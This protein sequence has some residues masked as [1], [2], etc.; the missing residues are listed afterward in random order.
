MWQ[1]TY[2]EAVGGL[3]YPTIQ[4]TADGGYVIATTSSADVWV[5]KLDASGNV[6]WQKTYGGPS[7]DQGN[8]IRQTAD[9]GYIVAGT[10][11]S[12]GAGGYDVWLLRLDGSGGITWQK[13]YGGVSGDYTY[14]SVAEIAGGG[15]VVSAMTHSFIL[16]GELMDAI[17]ILSVDAN[18][19]LFNCVP[20][21]MGASSSAT[22]MTTTS[23][24]TA[25]QATL[26]TPTVTV[27]TTGSAP[28][29]S[30]ATVET[31]CG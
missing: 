14:G 29:T 7:Y 27:T 23:S 11:A 2:R 21:G 1:R 20:P 5:L 9:G 26:G 17:W 12:F 19:S 13:T 6:V 4:Q 30:Q 22:V 24:G 3:A 10:T 16:P 28:G 15:F 31:Q 18:G 25:T 8:S